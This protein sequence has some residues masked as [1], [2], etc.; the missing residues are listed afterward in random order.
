MKPAPTAADLYCKH[1]LAVFRFLRRMTR[2]TAVAEDLTQE[3]FLRVVRGLPEYDHRERSRAWVFRIA[4][5]VATDALRGVSRRIEARPLDVDPPVYEN[6]MTGLVLDEALA[7]LPDLD[8]ELVLLREIAG[9]DYEEIA[10][11][12]GLTAD[13]VRMRLFRARSTLRIA[14]SPRRDQ[15]LRKA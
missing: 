1:G 3:V 5:N 13:A 10:S 8:R 6:P 4:R 9:L 11:T 12:T 14:L 15:A 2:E 7:A